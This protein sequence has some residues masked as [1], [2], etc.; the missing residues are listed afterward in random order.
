MVDEPPDTQLL[1]RIGVILR[2]FTGLWRVCGA[3]VAVHWLLLV[4]LRFGSII[5]EGSLAP[6]DRS[7]GPG[8]FLVRFP[9][10]QAAFRVRGEGS[11]SSVRE[12]YVRDCYLHHG[13]LA[14]RD[15]D[16]VVDLGANVG[17]FTNLALAH[18]GSVRVVAVEPSRQL[19]EAFELSLAL[20]RGHRER[21]QLLR[22]FVGGLP[23]KQKSIIET[24][25]NY[26][27][28]PWMSEAELIRSIRIDRVDFLKCDIEGGEFDLF[29]KDSRLL[30]MSRTLAVEIH[31]F[32]GD[33]ESFV[34]IV[35]DLG[36][37]IRLQ[38]NA[39]DGSCILLA[40]KVRRHEV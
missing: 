23:E 12:M 37:A 27:D 5:K 26:S 13:A 24:D 16:T 20:N 15:G 21:V 32:G 1:H 30:Q 17:N 10:C 18:G 14:I 34:Q 6:A 28:A 4:A 9:T 39:N 31:A 40:T 38:K 25:H 3:P 8:P 7:L 33:V 36:F 22:A 19:N 2:D 11:I 29:R 35:R